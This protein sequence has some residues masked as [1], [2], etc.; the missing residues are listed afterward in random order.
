MTVKNLKLLNFTL[1]LIIFNLIGNLK[2][3][4]AKLELLGENDYAFTQDSEEPQKK[5]LRNQK[6]IL[7]HTLKLSQEKRKALEEVRDLSESDEEKQSSRTT[8]NDNRNNATKISQGKL[9]ERE[10]NLVN[11]VKEKESSR[12]TAITNNNDDSV[13]NRNI[14]SKISQAKQSEEVQ[15]LTDFT[16]PNRTSSETLNFSND[17]PAKKQPRPNDFHETS[18][19]K[20]KFTEKNPKNLKLN[21]YD[22]IVRKLDRLTVDVSRVERKVDRLL[23]E[24]VNIKENFATVPDFISKYKLQLPINS[25]ECFNQFDDRLSESVF[26]EDFSNWTSRNGEKLR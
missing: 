20:E 17:D 7:S 13:E 26:Q 9:I 23:V 25:N 14:A 6:R 8:S 1:L 3:A 24:N 21:F 15:N 12:Q 10:Q 16:E 22:Y 2:E 5:A 18:I 11:S 4:E 19:H